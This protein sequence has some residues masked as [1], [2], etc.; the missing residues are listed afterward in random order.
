MRPDHDRADRLGPAAADTEGLARAARLLAEPGVVIR[1]HHINA[2]PT[3]WWCDQCDERE[4]KCVHSRYFVDAWE[5][6][7]Y[8][9]FDR[10][11]PRLL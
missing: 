7:F 1:S 11:S 10:S 8:L 9:G 4:E 2:V 6:S 3:L 5:K